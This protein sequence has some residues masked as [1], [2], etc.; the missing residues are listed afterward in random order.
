MIEL[1]IDIPK[2]NQKHKLEDVQSSWQN[3]KINFALQKSET[4]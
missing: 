4:L 3:E 2:T 1:F